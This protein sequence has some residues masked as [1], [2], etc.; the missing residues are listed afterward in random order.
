MTKQPIYNLPFFDRF[1]FFDKTISRDDVLVS[2]ELSLQDLLNEFIHDIRSIGAYELDTRTWTNVLT[3]FLTERE[4]RLL[5]IRILNIVKDDGKTMMKI[6]ISG[7]LC[8]DNSSVAMRIGYG[9]GAI[10]G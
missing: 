1:D 2:I 9:S 4:T 10:V 6:A 3:A 5:K 7:M 8:Y